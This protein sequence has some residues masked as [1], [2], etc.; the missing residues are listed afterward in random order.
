MYV[1]N[2]LGDFE[3]LLKTAL[4][5]Q[6][7]IRDFDSGNNILQ[8]S[9]ASI[10][11][12]GKQLKNL[13]NGTDLQDAATIA[14]IQTIIP[15]TLQVRLPDTQI[16]LKNSINEDLANIDNNRLLANVPIMYSEHCTMFTGFEIPDW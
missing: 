6:F 1:D 13:V 2:Q 8:I 4:G 15:N 11:V 7:Y 3:L 10:N 9:S 5:Q 16:H 14:Q 12:H